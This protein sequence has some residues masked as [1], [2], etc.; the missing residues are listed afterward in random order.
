MASTAPT[1]MVRRQF[2]SHAGSQL[3][4]N[5]NAKLTDH[6]FAGVDGDGLAHHPLR[7]RLNRNQDGIYVCSGVKVTSDRV[8]ERLQPYRPGEAALVVGR[9]SPL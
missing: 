6:P 8:Q 3:P 9:P 1:G 7:H 4:F 5:G 2:F